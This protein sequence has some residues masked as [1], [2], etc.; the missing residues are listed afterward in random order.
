MRQSFTK[1][2]FSSCIII[3]GTMS[4]FSKAVEITDTALTKSCR[5]L[6]NENLQFKTR[7]I[8]TLGIST[9]RALTKADDLRRK[10]EDDSEIGKKADPVKRK[11]NLIEAV[12]LLKKELKSDKPDFDKAKLHA[13]LGSMEYEIAPQ[14]P[15]LLEHFK[16]TLKFGK[17]TFSY[18]ELNSLRIQVG[19][20][21]M[22]QGK[23]KE[24]LKYFKDWLKNTNTHDSRAYLYIAF[25]YAN[26]NNYKETLCPAYYSIKTN[27]SPNKS[28]YELLAA[29]H[30][31]LKDLR[32]TAS[33]LKSGLKY[34]PKEVRFWE[35]LSRAYYSLEDNAAAA[36]VSETLYL[37]GKFTKAENYKF[38]SQLFSLNEVS[39]RSAEILEEGLN[40]KIVEKNDVNWRTVARSYQASSEVDKAISSYVKTATLSSKASDYM[41]LGQ[42]YNQ[43]KNWSKAVK[44]FNKVVSLAASKKEKGRA[45]WNKGHALFNSGQCQSAISSFEQASKYKSQSAR[46][47]NYIE[48]V[49][50]S[51]ETGKCQ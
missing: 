47:T 42:L 14:L 48:L 5:P 44:A 16:S 20:I 25:I 1:Y 39:F 37:Q 27:K 15:K 38:L 36:A 46:A 9:F 50:Y 10:E 24:A 17:D 22:S 43:K 29:T 49:K 21:L 7:P 18:K 32:G 34:F 4:F 23:Y 8:T 26:E 11:Q 30:N 40:K 41:M 19:S 6:I 12:N 51:I 35:N 3:I 2:L 33:V 28:A 45:Y 31:E 13:Y